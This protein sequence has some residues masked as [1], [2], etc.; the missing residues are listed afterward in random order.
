[1]AMNRSLPLL[2]STFYLI[3]FISIYYCYQS[4]EWYSINDLKYS[5]HNKYDVFRHQMSKREA[6]NSSVDIKIKKTSSTKKPII[7]SKLDVIQKTS[8]K[9]NKTG[10]REQQSLPNM[11]VTYVDV[12]DDN[13]TTL[14]S[15]LTIDHHIYYNST[16][17]SDPTLAM[18]F[19][20]NITSFPRHQ[21]V[22][23]EM[24]SNSHRR[25]AT[26]TLPFE[27]PFYGQTMTNITIATGG[28]L[29]VGDHVHSWLAATQYIAA[30][31]ANFDTSLSNS[32]TIQYAYNETA[33]VIQWDDVM[34]HDRTPEG[35][36]SFQIILLKNG[37][38]IFVYKDVPFS[39][40]DI[41]DS[42]HPVKVG[43]SDAYII[44]RTIFFIR[45]KTI[46]EYHRADLKK[47]EI[48]NN[49]AIYFKALPTCASL[50]TCDSCV[51]SNIGFECGW[52]ETVKRCSDGYD[53]QRQEWI[54]KNCDTLI[55]DAF[56]ANN[57]TIT[58]LTPNANISSS[59]QTILSPVPGERQFDTSVHIESNY[60]HNLEINEN[61]S[62][63]QSSGSGAGLVS[64]LIILAFFSGVAL[65]VFYAYK[66]P[67]SSSG[68][69][70]IRYRPTQWR[71][72]SS[73]ARY[74][75]ASIHM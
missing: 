60:G 74:T 57:L 67:Q 64:V 28:F 8:I 66:N 65:W 3:T 49:T 15:N 6:D 32:S 51:S 52:C 69:F 4:N 50:Q 56:C 44:D 13:Q 24:L 45:R 36:F 29:Y 30:L 68:Q 37:D 42:K 11:S 20:V 10:T 47:L 54:V 58:T 17:Y 53:R 40:Q 23:H 7:A 21:L 59:T 70:L 39:I 19:W 48:S 61:E 73:E 22:L 5:E 71:F 75:A 27:F 38:I 43:I 72:G 25:A 12:D 31:M 2:V 41:P 63:T 9:S 35:S 62:N 18:N 46:Y 16:F 26:V 55:K 33:F 34:L 14:P 1:M